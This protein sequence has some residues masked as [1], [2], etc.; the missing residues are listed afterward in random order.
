M[1]AWCR[2]KVT[3]SNKRLL[4]LTLVEAVCRACAVVCARFTLSRR[5]AEFD[6]VQSKSVRLVPQVNPRET[7]KE[8]ERES[9]YKLP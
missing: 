4:G 6:L 5:G 3:P 1:C 8:R 7:E 2:L 9:G